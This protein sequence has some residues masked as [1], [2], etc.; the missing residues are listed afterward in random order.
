LIPGRRLIPSVLLHV[1]IGITIENHPYPIAKI[2]TK[3]HD[4]VYLT[5][6]DRPEEGFAL[7]A[8][9]STFRMSLMH[10]QQT[11][12]NRIIFPQVKLNQVVDISWMRGLYC[13]DKSTPW[14]IAQALQQTKFTMDTEG[15]HVE[16]IVMLGMC[17]CVCPQPACDLIID[18]PLYVWIEREGCTIP[19][20]AG[21][22]DA[23]EW[24]KVT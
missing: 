17:R 12:H 18:Q 16:S 14:Y 15:A 13:E 3:S 8:K 5:P 6:A 21:Y 4:T 20:F 24:E 1:R 7:L 10:A 19:V 2:T 23:S 9:V 11:P 22:I